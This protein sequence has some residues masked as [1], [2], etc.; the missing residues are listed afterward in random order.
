MWRGSDAEPLLHLPVLDMCA[1]LAKKS[2]T[3]IKTETRV[4]KVAYSTESDAP[5]VA[6]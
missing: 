6:R 3:Q 2:M 5:A 1:A 4:C